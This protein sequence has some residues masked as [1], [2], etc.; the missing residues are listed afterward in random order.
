M[1][2][3]PEALFIQRRLSGMTR[4]M[5]GLVQNLEE[6]RVE[7]PQIIAPNVLEAIIGNLKDDIN[8]LLRE[9]SLLTSP[10][11]EELRQRRYVCRACKNVFTSPLVAGVCDECRA[12]GITTLDLPRPAEVAPGPAGGE[13]EV[14]EPPSAE[15]DAED[16]FVEK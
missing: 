2:T 4:Q 16:P 11:R 7:Y 10:H 1:S 6:F 14:L 15:A 5:T 8:V 3:D 13:L 12:R 9:M